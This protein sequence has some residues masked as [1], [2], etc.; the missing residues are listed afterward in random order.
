MFNL[1]P[2]QNSCLRPLCQRFFLHELFIVY[3]RL[4]PVNPLTT[5]LIVIYFAFALLAILNLIMT[6]RPRIRAAQEEGTV[7]AKEIAPPC[8]PA[9]FAGICQFPNL[10]AYRQ[11]LE[12]MM[13]D[14][15]AAINVY[16]RQIYSLAQVNAA[17]YKYVQRAIF[18][19]II[20]LVTELAII[21]YLFFTY[22]DAGVMPP[23]Q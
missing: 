18:L 7:N 5:T 20:A 1:R 23:I 8:E 3:Y 17:K 11:S 9:F 15:T 12:D 21:V 22:L 10:S 16:T 14:E 4:I 2:L 19:V 6:V 13:G